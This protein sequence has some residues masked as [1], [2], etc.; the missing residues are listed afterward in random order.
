MWLVNLEELYVRYLEEDAENAETVGW[1]ESVRDASTQ[2]RVPMDNVQL[3]NM[4]DTNTLVVH[5][6]NLQNNSVT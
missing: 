5:M 4:Q 6:L 1:T 3:H 2:L